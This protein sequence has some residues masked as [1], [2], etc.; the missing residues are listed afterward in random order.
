MKLGNVIALLDKKVFK[1][2]RD[3]SIGLANGKMGHC[4]YFYN[5]SEN[6]K[7]KEYQ[8]RAESLI[9][10]IFKQIGQMKAFDIINGLAGIGLG[11]DYLIENEFVEGNINHIL[12]DIDNVLFRKICDVNKLNDSDLLLQLQLIYYFIIR[13]QKQ[14]KNSENEYLF[15]E[16]I[17]S[18]INHI[19][20]KINPFFLEEPVAFSMENPSIQSLLVMSQCY[21]FYEGK[22]NRI[23]KDLSLHILSKIPVLHANKLCLLYAMDKIKGK[24]EIDGW[25]EHVKL[26]T[27]ELNL[28]CIIEHELTDEIY[29]SEG[30]P[31][32]YMLLSELS[33]YFIPN[34]IYKYKKLIVEKIEKSYLWEKLLCDED[35]LQQKNGLF[36]GYTGTSLLLHKHY[37]HENRFN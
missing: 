14:N 34:Q 18:T 2:S 25:N 5:I 36:S 26:L 17:I 27:R 4:I 24:I 12:K 30:F 1:F 23:L 19:S 11:F 7:N 3:F 21:E 10:D 9:D 15:R 22:I 37:K 31:A 33:N 29:L 6:S 32:I 16:A 13:L 35:Y 28:E 20:E 8:Q